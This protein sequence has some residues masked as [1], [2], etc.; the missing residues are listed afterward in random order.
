MAKLQPAKPAAAPE[1]PV[2][3]AALGRPPVQC[4]VTPETWERCR[5]D[6]HRKLAQAITHAP[7]TGDAGRISK[8]VADIRALDLIEP[9]RATVPQSAGKTLPDGTPVTTPEHQ[10]QLAEI[11]ER[12]AA[13]SSDT[14]MQAFNAKVARKEA[15]AAAREES[16]A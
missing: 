3:G 12:R 7:D 1:A 14:A 9:T 15:V 10:R 16:G 2:T 5:R 11:E 6:L 13:A 8:L 4:D